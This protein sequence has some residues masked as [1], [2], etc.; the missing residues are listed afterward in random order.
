MKNIGLHEPHFIGNELKYLTSCI[1]E[2]WVSSTG[3]Y[4]NLFEKKIKQITKA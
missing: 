2:N 1:K 4:L 3:R